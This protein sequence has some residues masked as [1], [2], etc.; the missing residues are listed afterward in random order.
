MGENGNDG[1]GPELTDIG[2]R[3][4]AQ[5][6]SRTLVNPTAPMPSFASLQE[7]SP[8]KF[9]AMVAFLGELKGGEGEG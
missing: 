2:A 1:P 7:Q 3:L 9:N 4:P 8:D 5:A 6:I